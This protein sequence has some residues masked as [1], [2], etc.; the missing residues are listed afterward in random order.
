M[1]TDPTTLDLPPFPPMDWDDCEWWVGEISLSF[2]KDAGLN[3]TPFDASVSRLPTRTQGDAMTH[4]LQN[5]DRVFAAVLDALWP[6]YQRM[7][8]KYIEYLG[9]NAD[10]LMP[11]LAQRDALAALIDLRQVHVHPWEKSG[12]SYA[13]LQFGCTWDVEHGLGVMMHNDRVVDL[14]GADVS[15]AW[16][17]EEADNV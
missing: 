4:L 10:R 3:V 17:P 9:D 8:P 13:G 5:G 6:Y 16:P 14:G 2:G 15:F 11:E 12:V 7:R 1:P